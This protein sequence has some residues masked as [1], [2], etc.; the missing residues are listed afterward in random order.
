MRAFFNI[1]VGVL[2]S[3]GLMMCAGEKKEE[4]K[5]KAIEGQIETG[6]MAVCPGCG[7][8]MEKSKMVAYEANGETQYYCS[9]ECKDYHLSQQKKTD[10]VPAPPKNN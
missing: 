4:V 5:E 9:R 7:M 3:A 1:F 6:Q 10:N 8:K 2:V